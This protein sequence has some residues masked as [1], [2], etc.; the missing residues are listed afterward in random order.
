MVHGA[1]RA[2]HKARAHL[3]RFRAQREGRRH[4]L[5]VGNAAG[6]NHRDIGLPADCLQQHQRRHFL[7]ILEA[8]A[9]C[10]LDN[11]AIHTRFNAAHRRSDGRNSM[12]DDDPRLLQRA[13][14]FA[15]AAR[16]SGHEFHA[17]SADMVE[18]RGV[19]EEHDR[20]VYAKGRLGQISPDEVS[21][22][23][24]PPALHTAEA[25]CDRA[26][27]PIGACTIGYFAPLCSRNRFISCLSSL[28]P[29]D[30]PI[31]YMISRLIL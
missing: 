21:M 17:R 20:Q 1:F 29:A 5:A 28:A 10:A 4:T 14:K 25:S 24:S 9:F 7:G 13:D 18:D 8:T 30:Q 12:I 22:I 15:R 23:P 2:R 26:I 3:D 27:Q 11:Q 6:S 19:L 31:G 16:R